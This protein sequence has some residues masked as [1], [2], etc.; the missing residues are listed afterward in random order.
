LYSIVTNENSL[1]GK[2]GEP[3]G[4]D[5]GTSPRTDIMARRKQTVKPLK[6][7]TIVELGAESFKLLVASATHKGI[8]LDRVHVQHL[9]ADVAPEEAIAAALKK[10]KIGVAPTIGMLPRQSANLRLM[11]LPSIDQAEIADMIDLQSARQTPYSRDEILSDYKLLGQTRRGT[12]T[13]VLLAIVQRALVRERYHDLE[14][15]G[16]D[17]AR[18]SVSTEG[19]LAWVR[20][21]GLAAEKAVAV[22][23]VDATGSDLIVVQQDTLVS[24]KHIMTGAAAL[25]EGDEEARRKFSDDVLRALDAGREG[26][27]LDIDRLVLTGAATGI[28][29]L[30]AALQGALKI[31]V[32]ARGMAS[33]AVEDHKHFCAEATAAGMSVTALVGAALA[34]DELVLNLCPDVVRMRRELVSRARDLS[35]LGTA[36]MAVLV[37]GSLWLVLACTFKSAALKQLG[38]EIEATQA[39]V[40]RVEQMTEVVREVHQRRNVRIAPVVVLP[41][42]HRCVP[43][44]VFIES[45]D[46][47]RAKRALVLNGTAPSRKEVRGLIAALEAEPLFV[48]AQES[49]K[50]TIGKDGRFVFQVSCGMEDTN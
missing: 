38:R 1:S 29:G 34:P 14:R 47:D 41:A 37:A 16:L 39:R 25:R 20:S 42:L 23:D 11:E 27:G 26:G 4:A 9:S 49:G 36:I 18:M 8:A 24:S 43:E 13:R 15:G 40:S 35:A 21:V 31:E 22:L 28:D 33:S 44:G 32:A 50:N 6:R 30:E 10:Y 3:V 46:Y 45:M 5:W 19:L 2:N 48:R 17:L 7:I 12:Y